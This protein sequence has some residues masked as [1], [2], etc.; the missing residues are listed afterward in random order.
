MALGRLPS[1]YR[2][3]FLPLYHSTPKDQRNNGISCVWHLQRPLR[4]LRGI[5]RTTHS[6]NHTLEEGDATSP[7]CW[8]GKAFILLHKDERDPW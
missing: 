1:V 6:E 3:A 4:A 8:D 5:D 7:Q 2:R